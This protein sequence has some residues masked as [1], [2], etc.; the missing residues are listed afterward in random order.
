L[1]LLKIAL[2]GNGDG[3]ELRK[4]LCE[5]LRIEQFEAAADQPRDQ[6][7]ERHFAGIALFAEHAFAEE[8]RPQRN[9][10]QSPKQLPIPPT[11][12]GMRMSHTVQGHIHVFNLCVDPGLLAAGCGFRAGAYDGVEITIDGDFVPVAFDG[13]GKPARHVE[14]VERYN[15]PFFR[16]D[17]KDRSALPAL[18]HGKQAHTVG[19][20]Q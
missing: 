17:P 11:F 18:C 9:A 6:M 3:T 2:G 16:G 8:C 14:A 15:S 12:D 1:Q 4:V 19:A 7:D 20:E 13:S 10:I 5:E